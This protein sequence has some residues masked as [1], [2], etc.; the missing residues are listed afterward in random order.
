M[1]PA[2][3]FSTLQGVSLALLRFFFS[4]SLTIDSKGDCHVRR[5]MR[6]TT[7]R[8]GKPTGFA[9]LITSVVLPVRSSL[10]LAKILMDR[11]NKLWF[12]DCTFFHLFFL[13]FAA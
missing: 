3:T 10:Q 1:A 2:S 9:D 12:L 8:A 6:S 5:R 7:M 11:T 13:G 4:I